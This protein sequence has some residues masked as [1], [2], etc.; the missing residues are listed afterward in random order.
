MKRASV[1]TGSSRL[2][3]GG[4][5]AVFATS[6]TAL[7]QRISVLLPDQIP[8]W[9]AIWLSAIILLLLGALA[10]SYRLHSTNRKL[11]ATQATLLES[12]ERFRALSDSSFGGIIIHEKGII[13]EC[14]KGLTEMTGFSH[15][16]LIGM[17]GFDLITPDTLNIVLSNIRKGYEKGYEVL[18]VRKDGSKYDLAIRG[19]NV[20]YKG[21]EVRVIEFRDIS[22]RKQAERLVVESEK[23]LRLA[24]RSAKQ[25][26]FDM[27]LRTGHS[28]ASPEIAQMLGHSPEEYQ[29]TI[30]GWIDSIHPEDRSK[31][32]AIFTDML[33]NDQAYEASYRRRKKDGSWIW[34]TSFAQVTQ[35]DEQGQAIRV[36]GLHMD[37]SE[38]KQAE[39]ELE[40]YRNRLE[41]L[42]SA[43]THELQIA[44]EAA[45]AANGA[46][47]AF[48]ANMSHEIRTPMNA[49]IGLSQLAL[50]T[51]LNEQQRDYI[52]K[53]LRS[54]RSLLGILNDILDYSKIEAGRIEIEK[55]DFSLEDI[56]RATA[57]L[58]SASA[59]EKGL[60]LFIEIDSDVPNL[61]IGD[62]LRLGQVLD[63]LVGNAIKFTECGEVHVRVDKEERTPDSLL[64]RFSVRDTGIGLSA[65]QAERL[66]QP[67]A[68]VDSSFARRFGGTG[69]GLTISK[70]LVEL[71]GG[72]ISLSSV[73]GQG[74]NFTF[75][76]RL[77]ISEATPKLPS[78]NPGLQN[79]QSMRALVIDDQ[80]TSLL[81]LRSLLERWNFEVTTALSGEE[82]LRQFKAANAEKRPFELLLIDWK[83]PGM[84]GLETAQAIEHLA[85]TDNVGTQPP[86]IIM[87]TAHKREHLLKASGA[88]KFDSVLL[89]PI[90]PSSLFDSL[91]NIQQGTKA[92][93]DAL[94][95]TFEQTRAALQP[96]QG[97]R[98]LLVEDNDLNRQVAEEFLMK[99]G[100]GVEL[101]CNGQEALSK[102]QS[103]PFD[104]V[105]MDLH[106][107]VMDGFEA[108]RR[109]RALPGHEKLPIIA[110]T[111]AAMTQ[112]RQA[113]TL[114][115]MND[116]IAKPIDARELATVLTR[117][118]KPTA[119]SLA[120]NRLKID[121][122]APSPDPADIK[123]L[124]NLLPTVS[125]QKALVR[126]GNKL[127]TY[128]NRLKSFAA[129]HSDISLK[130]D[131][132]LRQNQ[133]KELCLEAHDLKGEAGNLGLDTVHGLADTLELLI[134]SGETR[135][136]H[137]AS[138]A[139]SAE[140]NSLLQCLSTLN[141]ETT[142]KDTAQA[143]PFFDR[144]RFDYL[145]EKLDAQLSA[146]DMDA[147]LTLLELDSL[148][149]G[150]TF[151]REIAA[152][153]P[154]VQTLDYDEA[155]AH[156]K[157]LRST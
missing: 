55:T 48:L 134:K 19:K 43:R 119:D 137:A 72:T 106:M 66:F 116:H 109:I 1:V 131:A 14:N 118:I 53:V 79:L 62:P 156:V 108:T 142:G 64:L 47:S 75:T 2:W 97:A 71:M 152:I 59:E 151:A 20:H 4:G 93:P 70:Q 100:L 9:A 149:S 145:L 125:V 16:E 54:S 104:A 114:A 36:A 96:I 154:V 110:M 122:S 46:K 63:N 61:L 132:H 78:S 40:A 80:E 128:I 50:D 27:D 139:L 87:V 65:D 82:G 77:G 52:T 103:K 41:E 88:V 141:S 136:V 107:P 23:R 28:A 38:R 26:S 30:Q 12:E 67:F 83:M 133:L 39:L 91:I 81:I 90:T 3:A 102:V 129:R 150:T 24:M 15:E 85:C 45:E 7:E 68:Q 121:R 8:D 13:L 5:L 140:C 105:L 33:E 94:G 120:V 56:V 32:E 25:A 69:L 74:S 22:E 146:K 95:D 76:A 126:M 98:L 113:T 60:E 86:T 112:D 42:V 18:G 49:I 117:W 124:E 58:F 21:R 155:L 147:Q 157:R 123:N 37:I 31:V 127:P 144:K 44:K 89:K 138:A 10:T 73:L 34:I 115:G 17:N 51:P 6:T 111:A 153:T 101:A 35:R 143:A 29:P 148:V 11:R 135:S 57:D 130:I 84:S 92:R 99:C